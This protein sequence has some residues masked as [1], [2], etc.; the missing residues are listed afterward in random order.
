MLLR[1]SPH[2]LTLPLRSCLWAA[3]LPFLLES[4]HPQLWC[5]V[6][7]APAHCAGWSHIRWCLA[8]SRRDVAAVQRAPLAPGGK[9]IG[10][11]QHVCD[12]RRVY[13]HVYKNTSTVGVCSARTRGT[14]ITESS[15]ESLTM[16]IKPRLN[17]QLPAACCFVVR[18]VFDN[19]E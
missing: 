5:T 9:D 8:G 1:S 13:Q 11:K 4:L 17:M 12:M 7:A 3:G 2:A 16:N 14:K 18:C 10:C 15:S 19:R 6:P